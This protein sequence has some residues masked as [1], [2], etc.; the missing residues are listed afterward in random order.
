MK[1]EMLYRLAIWEAAFSEPVGLG[2]M[3]SDVLAC[4]MALYQARIKAE[5]PRFYQLQIR[6]PSNGLEN[7]F[8]LL[9]VHEKRVPSK[10]A[11]NYGAI[12]LEGVLE[13]DGLDV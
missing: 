1:D 2:L 8:N 11:N 13:L 12:G 4:K 9:I 3:V 10:P 5:D 7:E 6:T